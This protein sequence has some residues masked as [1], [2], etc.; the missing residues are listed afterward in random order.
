MELVENRKYKEKDGKSFWDTLEGVLYSEYP[1]PSAYLDQAPPSVN[2][3]VAPAALT[4]HDMRINCLLYA[5]DVVLIAE[6]P[7]MPALLAACE[8]NSRIV[9]SLSIGEAPP[10]ALFSTDSYHL[11]QHYLSYTTPPCRLPAPSSISAFP[12]THQLYGCPATN[13]TQHQESDQLVKRLEFP[14]S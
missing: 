2:L 4:L 3:P 6:P 12:S 5:D 1:E 10:G 9:G 8:D 14:W 13:R 7:I 11:Y